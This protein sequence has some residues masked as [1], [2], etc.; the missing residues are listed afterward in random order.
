[1]PDFLSASSLPAAHLGVLISAAVQH[2]H[3]FARDAASTAARLWRGI[4]PDLP[5]PTNGLAAVGDLGREDF[6]PITV[7][8]AV[9]FALE[10]ARQSAG[11]PGHEA[12]VWLGALRDSAADRLASHEL[13]LH[14]R[15][16]R[17]RPRYEQSRG[18]EL[19]PWGIDDLAGLFYGVDGDYAGVTL[20]EDLDEGAIRAVVRAEFFDALHTVEAHIDAGGP[21][22]AAALRPLRAALGDHPTLL[23]GGERVRAEEAFAELELGGEHR[24]LVSRILDAGL[25]DHWRTHRG[26][27]VDWTT[28]LSTAD[29]FPDM[30]WLRRIDPAEA[31]P[32]PRRD[33][34]VRAF[35]QLTGQRHSLPP[36]DGGVDWHREWQSQFEDTAGRI[37]ATFGAPWLTPGEAH[38]GPRLLAAI[39]A[40][41]DDRLTGARVRILLAEPEMFASWRQ[42]TNARVIDTIAVHDARRATIR[43][44]ALR[45]GGLP[46]ARDLG[47]YPCEGGGHEALAVRTVGQIEA[48]LERLSYQVATTPPGHGV[49]ELAVALTLAAET[50]LLDPAASARLKVAVSLLAC[51]YQLAGRDG[52]TV[53]AD[54]VA[55][56]LG[57]HVDLRA[58]LRPAPA[59]PATDPRGEFLAAPGLL[60]LGI[61]DLTSVRTVSRAQMADTFDAVVA[62][63]GRRIGGDLADQVDNA[64]YT[65]RFG[66]ALDATERENYEILT[67]AAVS[68]RAVLGGWSMIVGAEGCAAWL[69]ARDQTRV[70]AAVDA[71]Q[72]RQRGADQEAL[73]TTLVQQATAREAAARGPLTRQSMPAVD[74]DLLAGVL[75]S[76]GW[77]PTATNARGH[78][79]WA[80][81]DFD[82]RLTVPYRVVVDADSGLLVTAVQQVAAL[83]YFRNV[84]DILRAVAAPG[85]STAAAHGLIEVMAGRPT[86]LSPDAP[87]T[88]AV[89]HVLPSVPVEVEVLPPM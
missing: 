77:R 83:D 78:R 67:A 71:W 69:A 48:S 79:I 38:R 85:S 89:D 36:A 32:F 44:D 65:A 17:L 13:F 8:K 68:E 80:H 1:M 22:V 73:A 55:A 42:S 30:P 75:T 5:V 50:G 86:H 28:R 59:R 37:A 49:H 53:F 21:G 27:G 6:H 51:G 24:L 11:L 88:G 19:T 81:D 3:I 58:V 31:T 52:R 82:T 43:L 33:E 26:A 10:C 40:N 12:R 45:G 15:D 76:R 7:I 84:A 74:P 29:G 72:A 9:D 25:N 41:A 34:L 14:L 47:A 64:L 70:P 39:V 46:G 60:T 63:Q 56:D 66:H 23:D 4:S 35:D 87:G 2:E 61:T 16:G 20:A 57:G 18:Y 62:Q 54:A